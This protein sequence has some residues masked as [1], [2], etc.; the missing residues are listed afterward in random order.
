MTVE[1]ENWCW[2]NEDK[3]DYITLSNDNLTVTHKYHAGINHLIRGNE[4]YSDGVHSFKIRVDKYNGGGDGYNLIGFATSDAPRQTNWD[5]KEKPNFWGVQLYNLQ[6]PGNVKGTSQKLASVEVKSG[7]IVTVTLDTANRKLDC[8][9]ASEKVSQITDIQWNGQDT[10]YPALYV[11]A[12][13]PN[14]YTLYNIYT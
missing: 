10:L 14:T 4:G 1:K 5:L 13:E 12:L 6:A 11:G 8:Y 2:N 9:L 7:D 3:D